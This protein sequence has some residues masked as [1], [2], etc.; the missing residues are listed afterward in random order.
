[1]EGG[2]ECGR[3]TVRGIEADVAVL[4]AEREAGRRDVLRTDLGLSADILLRLGRHVSTC[5]RCGIVYTR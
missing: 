1:M 4:D 3:P 2:V 5:S